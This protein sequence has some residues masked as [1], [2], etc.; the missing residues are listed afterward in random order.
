MLPQK[1]TLNH[2]SQTINNEPQNIRPE[3]SWILH[4]NP[5][6]ALTFPGPKLGNPNDKKTVHEDPAHHI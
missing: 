3:P 4:Q 6:L 5:I 1:E 2:K